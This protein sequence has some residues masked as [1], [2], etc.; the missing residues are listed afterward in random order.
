MSRVHEQF[1]FS[2]AILVIRVETFRHLARLVVQNME[3]NKY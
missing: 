2:Y 3:W 1:S